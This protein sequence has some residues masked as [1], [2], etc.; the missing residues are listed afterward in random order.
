MTTDYRRPTGMSSVSKQTLFLVVVSL[1]VLGIA[2]IYQPLPE[3][4]PQP[5]KYR[6]LSFGAHIFSK[7]VRQTSFD[8]IIEFF[9]L[10]SRVISVNK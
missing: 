10:I 5:W 3:G 1:S 7:L 2:L 8:E 6:F 4:F 9:Y